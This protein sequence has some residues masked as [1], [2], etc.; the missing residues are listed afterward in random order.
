MKKDLFQILTLVERGA[1]ALSLI[2]D[3]GT[4]VEKAIEFFFSSR[5]STPH[6]LEVNF[7]HQISKQRKDYP[8]LAKRETYWI[9]SGSIK[10]AGYRYKVKNPKGVILY[11][12][13]IR[14]QADDF[15]AIGQD[16]FVR[17]GYEVFAID[18]SNSGRST[19]QGIDSL[20]VG[21]KDVYNAT[22]FITE[23]IY[24]KDIP[25]YL[26][27][28]SWGGY[29]VVA[30]TYFGADISGVASLSGFSSPLD[31]MIG[32]PSEKSGLPLGVK[33]E[34]LEEVCQKRSDEFYDLSAIDAI[35]KNPT[36]PYFIAI[37]NLDTTVPVD[38]SSIYHKVKKLD[39]RNCELHMVN[40]KA[41]MDIFLTDD[42]AKKREE[43]IEFQKAFIKERGSNFAKL[44]VEDRKAFFNTVHIEESSCINERLFE[45][46]LLFFERCKI[47]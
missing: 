41:H 22:K 43:Y 20:S 46:I 4:P 45:E 36:L 32:L 13:G 39:L 12:H 35:K 16:Y 10:L 11:V 1:K 19:G 2:A 7:I 6:D 21:A 26:F 3:D 17:Q 14:G 47:R 38:K 15:Y 42:S 40:G 34:D 8:S 28:H 30:S 25:I 24:H 5:F 27:G 31:E 33:R 44:N 29:S 23:R 37:G 9:P 18:L